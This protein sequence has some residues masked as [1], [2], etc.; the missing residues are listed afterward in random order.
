MIEWSLSISDAIF[1][2]IAIQPIKNCPTVH[3]IT[4]VLAGETTLSSC[5][6]DNEH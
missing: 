2:K 3:D 6:E 5:N 4:S 1:S